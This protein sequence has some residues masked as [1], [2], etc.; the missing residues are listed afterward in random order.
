MTE[1][2]QL[3]DDCMKLAKEINE[4]LKLSDETRKKYKEIIILMGEGIMRF[5]ETNDKKYLTDCLDKSQQLFKPP[6]P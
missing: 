1:E 2:K 6:V 5:L 3:L 4:A